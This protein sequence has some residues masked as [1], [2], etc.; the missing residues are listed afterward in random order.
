VKRQ[1]LIVDDDSSFREVLKFNME[2][3]GF[4]V[5]TAENGKDGLLRFLQHRPPL[6][7]TDMKMPV[8][9]GMELLELL[10]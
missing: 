2:E 1:I 7:V 10:L 9:D 6:V 5:L 8:M 4:S 3:E